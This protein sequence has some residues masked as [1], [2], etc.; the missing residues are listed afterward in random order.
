M[1]RAVQPCY[2][3]VL[4]G[5]DRLVRSLSTTSA[6]AGPVTG[7]LRVALP[8]DRRDAA[9]ERTGCHRRAQS[10]RIQVQVRQGFDLSGFAAHSATAVIASR[11]NLVSRGPDSALVLLPW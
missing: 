4:P 5:S 7:L 3:T 10:A 1:A 6:R 9:A 8:R 11:G 2:R